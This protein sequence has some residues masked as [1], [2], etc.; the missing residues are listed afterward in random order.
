VFPLK[1]IFPSAPPA[2]GHR[3]V[4]ALAVLSQVNPASPPNTPEL[5]NCTDVNG[6]LGIPPEVGTYAE[7]LDPE[8]WNVTFVLPPGAAGVVPL[9]FGLET[10]EPFTSTA[11][12]NGP[13]ERN[14]TQ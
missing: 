5:L 6:R 9:K 12:P 4:N 14:Y 1:I 2:V 7:T 8:T 10:G 3:I 11:V 13:T